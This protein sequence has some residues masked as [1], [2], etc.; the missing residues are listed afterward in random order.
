MITKF[1]RRLLPG[2]LKQL[3]RQAANRGTLKQAERVI[4]GAGR[5]KQPGWASCEIFEVN[6]TDRNDFSAYWD[7]NSRECF[8]AEHVWEHLTAADGQIAANH[9][10]E[11][12]KPGGRLRIAVPDGNSPDPDYIE[13]VRV[14][15]RGAG[16]HDHKVLYT[17]E[18]MIAM[19][20]KAGFQPQALEFFDGDGKFQQIEWNEQDGYIKRCR[21][22]DP[23]NTLET[24]KYTSL[25]VDGI[26]P[27]S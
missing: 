19:F 20:E 5:T 22:N 11:F 8:L 3:L 18:T 16:A 14:G 12:L 6:I 25:I 26:K 10:F 4:I 9:C 13:D 2:R 27:I 15:G 7:P 23:R 1:V 17:V 24:L 21:K